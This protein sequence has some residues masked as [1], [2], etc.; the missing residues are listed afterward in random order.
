MKQYKMYVSVVNQRVYNYPDDAP[1]EYE[2]VVTEEY[3]PVFKRLFDQVDSFE[4]QNFLRSHF[5]LMPKQFGGFSDQIEIRIQ[6]I[7]ALIHEF[8]NEESKRFIEQLPYFR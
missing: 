5:P 3:V 2:V 8:T 7:Y 1:W 6:K 4:F